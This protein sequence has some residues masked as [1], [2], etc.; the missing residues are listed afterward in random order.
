M[1][2]EQEP[3]RKVTRLIGLDAA[4]QPF[5]IVDFPSH[6]RLPKSI[7]AWKKAMRRF[8]L[9]DDPRLQSGVVRFV[10]QRFEQRWPL[11]RA[12]T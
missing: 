11:E 8:R 2:G 5:D 4:D 7:R 12:A 6:K 10:R 9:A 3:L 1:A